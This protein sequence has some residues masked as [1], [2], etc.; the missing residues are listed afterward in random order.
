MLKKYGKSTI[1][2]VL[3][4]VIKKNLMSYYSTV[5]SKIMAGTKDIF[6][7]NNVSKEDRLAIINLLDGTLAKM[8][9]DV[10]KVLLDAE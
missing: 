9:M 2:H 3:N 1:I 5:D 10:M 6:E 8:N 7:K 4:I